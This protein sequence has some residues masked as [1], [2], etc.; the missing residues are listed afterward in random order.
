LYNDTDGLDDKTLPSKLIVNHDSGNVQILNQG[1]N[2]TLPS[3]II[4]IPYGTN[5]TNVPYLESKV[6]ALENRSGSGEGRSLIIENV[7]DA[8]P[9]VRIS[10]LHTL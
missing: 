4:N 1:D 8:N 9:Y 10:K 3:Q 7:H 6:A 2:I 5:I